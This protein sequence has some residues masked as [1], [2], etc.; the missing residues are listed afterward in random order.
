[1]TSAANICQTGVGDQPGST[2]RPTCRPALTAQRLRKELGQGRTFR[3]RDGPAGA[4]AYFSYSGAQL[5]TSTSAGVFFSLSVT[6]TDSAVLQ[7]TGTSYTLAPTSLRSVVTTC[8]RVTTGA[9]DFT[10]ATNLVSGGL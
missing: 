7:G 6:V 9:V 8:T 3:Q 1:M 5:A 4:T 10:M 2:V